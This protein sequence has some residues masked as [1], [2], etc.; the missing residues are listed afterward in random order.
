MAQVDYEFFSFDRGSIDDGVEFQFDVEQYRAKFGNLLELVRHID[1]LQ[2]A[3]NNEI[4]Q[5]DP[6]AW[7]QGMAEPGSTYVLNVSCPRTLGDTW[8][9]LIQNLS[10]LTFHGIEI[11]CR[12]PQIGFKWLGNFEPEKEGSPA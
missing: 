1:E 6:E 9:E 2:E 10:L 4:Q 11:A 8:E 5:R 12:N 7:E 3:E